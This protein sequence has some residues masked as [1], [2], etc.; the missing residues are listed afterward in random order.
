[1]KWH[2][3]EQVLNQLASGQL[4]EDDT[5][6]FKALWQQNS[7]QSISSISNGRGRGWVIVGV[8]DQ[9]NV[10]NNTSGQLM[11]QK[12]KIENHIRQYLKPSSAVQYISIENVKRKQC[13]FIEIRDPGEPVSWNERFYKRVGTQT[14][15]MTPGEKKALELKRPGLDFSN[16]EYDGKIDSSLVV[17][18]AGFLPQNNGNW[19]K[20]STNDI[21]SKLNIKNKNVSGVLFGDFTFRLIHYKDEFSPLDQDE[22]QG[23]YRLLQDDFISHIQSWTRKRAMTLKPGSLSVQEEQPYPEEVLREVIV[24]AVAH[25]AFEKKGREIKVELYKNKIRVLNHCPSEAR[26]FIEKRFSKEHFSHNPFLM[27]ILRMAGFSDDLGTGKNKIFKTMIESGRR[28]PVFEYQSHSKNYGVLSVTIYNEQPNKHFLKLLERF[29]QIYKNKNKDKYKIAAALVLWK[30]KP[31]KDILSYMDKYHHNL[32]LDV[33][34]DSD[35]PFL[36]LRKTNSENKTVFKILLKRWVKNQLEGQKSKVF[37]RSEEGELKEVLQEYAY[38]ENK[39]GFINNKE[40]RQLFD[41]S[42]DSQSEAVQLSKLFQRWAKE[43]FLEKTS[44]RGEWRVKTAPPFLD[45]KV[46]ADFIK[47]ANKLK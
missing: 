14:E 34:K 15:E 40:A 5:I 42:V 20:L 26:E 18:F 43:G 27:K 33:L 21:L 36:V 4:K 41:L 9:G 17:D 3:K 31:L 1:M 24:N 30:D 16:F 38:K 45:S 44:K 29:K 23:L 19:T 39:Q 6:E 13:I 35:S 25:S 32:T 47:S 2:T 22:K 11:N 46:I 28:E 8:N 12:N 37:S 10:T 7:G